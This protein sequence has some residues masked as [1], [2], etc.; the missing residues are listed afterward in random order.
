MKRMHIHIAV[1]NVGQSIGFYSALF[2]ANPL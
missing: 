2:D 1:E